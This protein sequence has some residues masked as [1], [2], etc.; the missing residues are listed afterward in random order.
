MQVILLTLSTK[1][2]KLRKTKTNEMKRL[3][4]IY[5]F[6]KSSTKRIF[7]GKLLQIIELGCVFPVRYKKKETSEKN[8]KSENDKTI[9]YNFKNILSTIVCPMHC[10]M[11]FS[12]SQKNCIQL[13]FSVPSVTLRLPM[14]CNIHFLE[15]HFKLCYFFE[16]DMV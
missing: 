11:S 14:Q 9:S 15:R 3:L 8:V 7:K 12:G 4:T 2:F 5:T 1:D 6:K 16:T 10:L 13:S